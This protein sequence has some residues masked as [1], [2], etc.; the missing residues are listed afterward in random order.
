VARL[1]KAI[2][3]DPEASEFAPL[4]KLLAV[5]TQR[6]RNLDPEVDISGVMEGVTRVLDESITARSFVIPDSKDDE[7]P[8][9]LSR[10]DFEA[11][12]KR[13]EQGRKHT[14]AERLRSRVNSKLRQMVRLNKTRT[15]YQ[16]RLQRLIEEY[17][18]GSLN[19]DLY[20]KALIKM[21]QELNEEDQRPIGEGLSEEELAV[22]DI[23]IKPDM[24]LT[25]KE[26]EEVKRLAK[27]LLETLKR[28][29]CARLAQEAASKSFSS[30]RCQR[31]VGQATRGLHGQPLLA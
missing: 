29:A 30:R 16:E 27:D 25:E 24:T 17:N 11:L 21:A 20:F 18:A 5:L 4:T 6:I 14:E 15:E 22:F 19:I 8:L 7:E 10:I 31:G 3:L 26:K 1:Y 2:L 28:E 13:F 23:L 9:D 12:R